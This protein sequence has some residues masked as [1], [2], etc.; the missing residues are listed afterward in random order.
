MGGWS[1]RARRERYGCTG[2]DDVA[3]GG[4]VGEGVGAVL[5][6]PGDGALLAVAGDDDGLALGRV[7]GRWSGVVDVHGRRHRRHFSFPAATRMGGQVFGANIAKWAFFVIHRR[8]RPT[9]TSQLF[10]AIGPWK[11]RFDLLL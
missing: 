11:A 4:D 1:R 2:L 8:R 3:V 5:L 7:R 9:A 10:S 6:D